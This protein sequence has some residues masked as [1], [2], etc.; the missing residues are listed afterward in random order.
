MVAIV[1][2]LSVSPTSVIIPS[3]FFDFI[4][5]SDPPGSAI[6]F[7]IE[8]FICISPDHKSEQKKLPY[9]ESDY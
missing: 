7:G 6:C 2:K 1:N 3:F 8:T 5:A 9:I 4:L